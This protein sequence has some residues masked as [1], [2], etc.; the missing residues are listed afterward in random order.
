MK[1]L[2]V[3]VAVAAVVALISVSCNNKPLNMD[4]DSSRFVGL[5]EITSGTNATVFTRGYWVFFDDGTVKRCPTNWYSRGDGF[6]LGAPVYGIWSYEKDKNMLVTDVEFN[7]WVI[8]MMEE[9]T[10]TATSTDEVVR[11]TAHRLSLDI[12]PTLLACVLHGTKWTGPELGEWTF[13]NKAEGTQMEYRVYDSSKKSTVTVGIPQKLKESYPEKQITKDAMKTIWGNL[14][15]LDTG[16][17]IKAEMTPKYYS[18]YVKFVTTI[19]SFTL[20]NPFSPSKSTIH[21]KMNVKKHEDWLS[22]GWKPSNQNLKLEETFEDT[23]KLVR[24]E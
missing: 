24:Q 14:S 13:S 3:A 16:D 17:G 22:V 9:G 23:F 18:S 11:F 2:F 1:R 10:W 12:N 5:W 7:Q 20:T 19:D 15:F 8:T 4:K 6:T 21:F